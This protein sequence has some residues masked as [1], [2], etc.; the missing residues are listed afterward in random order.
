ME[1]L[2]FKPE[3]SPYIDPLPTE[4]ITLALPASLLGSRVGE[5]GYSGLISRVL[6]PETATAGRKKLLSWFTENVHKRGPLLG[7]T[8][9]V[10]GQKELEGLCGGEKS[11]WALTSPGSAFES[12]L[13]H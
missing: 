10:D 13:C 1:E 6:N 5:D 2:E 8:N 11:A 12:R 4:T 9:V 3:W 7:I